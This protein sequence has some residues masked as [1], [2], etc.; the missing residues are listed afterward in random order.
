MS[1][2]FM[3]D[4]VQKEQEETISHILEVVKKK[5][6]PT[7]ETEHLATF[8]SALFHVGLKKK[9]FNSS[10]TQPRPIIH[11]IS[12]WPAPVTK[13]VQKEIVKPIKRPL[14]IP[15][16]PVR[17]AAPNLLPE[18][19]PLKP[20]EAP[21]NAPIPP[22]PIAAQTVEPKKE[23]YTVLSFDTPIGIIS[24]PKGENN[25]PV[26]TV[27]EPQVDVQLLTT[28]KSLIAKDVSK[29]YNILDNKEYM[30]EKCEKAAKKIKSFYSDDALPAMKY[31][32]KRDM[33]GFRRL[34]PLMQDIN[35]K[36]IYVDGVNKP[37]FIEAI[38]YDKG[39]TNIQFNDAD[40]LNELIKKIAKA[41]GNEISE[42]KPIL[43]TVFQGFKIQAI[44]GIGNTTS[45]LVIKKVLS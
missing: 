18:N 11:Q 15:P 42:Q 6:Y 20:L 34:D 22:S 39:K 43:A 2:K 35:V 21:Q 7:R 44:L 25:K 28:V 31:Y 16:R 41:T 10:I 3:L 14:P 33:T 36:S 24:D 32:L 19:A 17:S 29:D 5:P 45:K 38:Q 1:I 4:R 27:I 26:Y 37:V 12:K 9:E 30:K 23:E 13:V 40:D 8:I